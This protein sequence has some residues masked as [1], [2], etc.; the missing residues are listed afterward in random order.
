MATDAD[1]VLLTGGTGISKRDNTHEAVKALLDKELPGFGEL[2][3]SFSY[4]E[5]GAAAML[6][7]AI[8]GVYRSTVVFSM[9]GSLPAVRLAMQEL[10]IPEL[11][12]LASEIR[13]HLA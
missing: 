9:P 7:R 12:H 6:S 1:V 11:R 10:I 13:K 3:R 5:I 4:Q 8:G 2:F